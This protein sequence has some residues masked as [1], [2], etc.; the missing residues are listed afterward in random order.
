[1][2]PGHRVLDPVIEMDVDESNKENVDPTDSLELLPL[3]PP[4]SVNETSLASSPAIV[5]GRRRIEG[6]QSLAD[7]IQ[8]ID[9]DH[10][11][12]VDELVNAPYEGPGGTP[13]HN[14][15]PDSPDNFPPPTPSP[16]IGVHNGIEGREPL[17]S[18][19]QRMRQDI[20]RIPAMIP[21]DVI[22]ASRASGILE[23]WIRAMEDDSSDESTMSS[24]PSSN[25]SIDWEAYL[26]HMAM[27]DDNSSDSMPSLVYNTENDNHSSNSS[28]HLVANLENSIASD[29]LP[30]YPEATQGTQPPIV[31]QAVEETRSAGTLYNFF[32]IEDN[33]FITTGPRPWRIVRLCTNGDYILVHMNEFPVAWSELAILEKLRTTFPDL[34]DVPY[35]QMC[36]RIEDIMARFLNVNASYVS[37]SDK[38]IFHVPYLDV[39]KAPIQDQFKWISS[40]ETVSLDKVVQ[41]ALDIIAKDFR[42]PKWY[43]HTTLMFSVPDA[44]ET[45]Y[46]LAVD[47]DNYHIGFLAVGSDNPW[48][49][50]RAHRLDDA[51]MIR[52]SLG[53]VV[54]LEIGR[55]AFDDLVY[56]QGSLDHLPIQRLT[57]LNFLDNLSVEDQL[58]DDTIKLIK[59]TR[60]LQMLE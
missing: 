46:Q 33:W 24:S 20:A 26:T 15:I 34:D 21:E 35:E 12:W 27:H 19:L 59:L 55:K 18:R 14:S 49:A 51:W 41:N 37:T 7:Y 48:S 9:A 6:Q 28:P 31:L 30:S 29:E 42:A 40:R 5:N 52:N 10:I 23:R 38:T 2:Q 54:V 53:E 4:P 32:K 16:V 39:I 44:A 47:L 1:M 11:W 17:P 56:Y 60:E 13:K 25:D 45:L 57:T 22:N 58:W 8:S 3:A 50:L 36:C 43:T